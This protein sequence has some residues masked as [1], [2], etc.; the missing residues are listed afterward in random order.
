MSAAELHSTRLRIR[1]WERRDDTTADRWPPYNEPLDQLWNLPRPFTAGNWNSF[2]EFGVRRSW[3]VDDMH[4][5]LMGRISLREIDNRRH[6]ARLGITFGAPFV[7]R[8]LG[9][10]ALA[11]FLEHFFGELGFSAMLLDVAA[12]NIR[13]VRC[14]DRLGFRQISSD[15][16]EAGMLFDRHQLDQPRFQHLRQYFREGQRGVWVEFFEMRLDRD[17]WDARV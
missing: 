13:A 6:E 14:Y 11:I 17:S 10:E 7:G 9:T 2:G 12:P 3:A 4:G 8:G 1:Q 5:T 15:W 16:R